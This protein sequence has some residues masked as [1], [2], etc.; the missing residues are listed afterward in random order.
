M[1]GVVG[2]VVVSSV[3]IGVGVDVFVGC[4]VVLRVSY[5]GIVGGVAVDVSVCMV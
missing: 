2:D 1:C 4:V 5:V 3:V